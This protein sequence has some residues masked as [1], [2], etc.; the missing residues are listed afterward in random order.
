M[1][2]ITNRQS[3][4]LSLIIK[5]PNKISSFTT[6]TIPGRGKGNNVKIIADEL[7]TEY[8]DRMEKVHGLI[9]TRRINGV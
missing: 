9:S 8:I 6:L 4:M 2:E 7:N 3:S 1:I 5:G